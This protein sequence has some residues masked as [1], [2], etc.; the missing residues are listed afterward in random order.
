MSSESA[1]I[2]VDGVG[3][4]YRMYD[5]P[6][7]RLWQGLFG[8]HRTFFR[9]FW[10]LRGVGFEV[11]RG[12]TLG[13]VGRNGS[14]KSTLL[15]MI[16]G[17]LRP[18]EGSVQ[19]QGR[20]AALLELG[21]GF[22]PEF[23]GRENVYLN[24]A[25]LGLSRDE[26][27]RRFDAIIAFADIG[28]F[29]D[30]P[31]RTYSSGMA[32]R[33]AFAVIA[34]VD[35]DVLIIDEALSVGDAY[36]AQKCMRFLREFR[37]HGTL[38]FVSHDA[39]AVIALCERAAW[40]EN[41]ALRMVGTAREVVETYLAELHVSERERLAGEQVALE[42]VVAPIGEEDV[43]PAIATREDVDAG[44]FA[45]PGEAQNRLVFGAGKA[46]IRDVRLLQENS[47][48]ALVLRGGEV[49]E[50]AI[51]AEALQSVEGLIFGFYVKDRLGQRVFGE[52]S[53]LAYRDA[54]VAGDAGE[55]LRARFRFRMP[56][57]APGIYMIDVAVASGTQ[58]DH[59]QQHWIHDALDFRVV[60]HAACFGLVGVPMIDVKIEAGTSA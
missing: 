30:Q 15:Q 49:V 16:A 47:E 43:A 55:A 48:P 32:V 39:G 20:V 22:N 7:H 35:A 18:T 28:E 54:P 24:A 27:E 21:S 53:F 12:E 40:L 46:R 51:D 59:T 34:H 29:I 3:K 1:V 9:E 52:N 2:R 37:E 58:L 11:R 19:V 14:G 13:I 42:R 10:A 8:S 60:E 31:V 57:L 41:G 38:L 33:L 26:T 50:L 6:S 36:F 25:I 17:T 45:M 23:T 5:S 56:V 44:A 4:S